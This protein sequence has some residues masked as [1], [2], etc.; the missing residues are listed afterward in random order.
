MLSGYSG[1]KPEINNKKI[2]RKCINTWS[3]INVALIIHR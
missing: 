3:L 1:I 2:S